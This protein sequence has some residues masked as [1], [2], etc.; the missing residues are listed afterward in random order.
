[1]LQKLFST[2][3]EKW[4][5]RDEKHVDKNAEVYKLFLKDA[6]YAVVQSLGFTYKVVESGVGKGF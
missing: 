6:V 2:A 3:F 5:L 4:K 1:M